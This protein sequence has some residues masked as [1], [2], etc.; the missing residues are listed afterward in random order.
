M[1][2]WVA[3][4]LG[5]DKLWLTLLWISENVFAIAARVS[6]TSNLVNS[7]SK[8]NTKLNLTPTIGHPYNK[9]YE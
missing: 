2:A 9:F 3:L 1:L 8:T 4:V 6:K 5:L 7:P